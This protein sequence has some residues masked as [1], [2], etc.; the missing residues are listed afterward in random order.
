[1]GGGVLYAYVTTSYTCYAPEDDTRKRVIIEYHVR[2]RALVKK[3][4]IIEYTACLIIRRG[5][6]VYATWV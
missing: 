6:A 1:M 3:Y 2:I 4:T 5:W